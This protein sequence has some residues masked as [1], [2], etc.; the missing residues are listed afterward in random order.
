MVPRNGAYTVLAVA[1]GGGGGGGGSARN[2]DGVSHQVGGAGGAAGAVTI[3]S[4]F[5]RAGEQFAVTVGGGGSPGIGGAANGGSGT[6][7]GAGGPSCF[8]HVA[9]ADGGSGGAGSPGNS[10]L[11]VLNPIAAGN[12]SD[13][14]A[15]APGSGGGATITGGEVSGSQNLYAWPG[16]GGGELRPANKGGA[17]A[18]RQEI[19]VPTRPEVVSAICRPPM[20]EQAQTTTLLRAEAEA[21]AEAGALRPVLEAKADPAG[22][23]SWQSRSWNLPGQV[24]Y[25]CPTWPRSLVGAPDSLGSWPL[26]RGHRWSMEASITALTRGVVVEIKPHGL[27]ARRPNVSDGRGDHDQSPRWLTPSRRSPRASIDGTAHATQ[28]W[29]GRLGVPSPVL[30]TDQPEAAL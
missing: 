6:R 4:F 23:D 14:T 3:N 18:D 20:E 5:G 12:S 7:G 15:R 27:T 24:A 21:E 30:G 10:S 29:R 13:G 2:T 26:N 8:P 11:T 1:G 9:I 16:G 22:G 25:R 17:E 28:L 19:A